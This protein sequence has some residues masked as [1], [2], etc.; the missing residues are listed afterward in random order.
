[1]VLSPT[2]LTSRDTALKYSTL[3]AFTCLLY[4]HVL[5]SGSEVELIWSHRWSF[6]KALF[7]FTRY[8]ALFAILFGVSVMFNDS[9][10]DKFCQ[11][12]LF[13]EI[14]STFI[15][16]LS[17]DI[18]LLLR[19]YAVYERNSKILAVVVTLCAAESLCILLIGFLRVPVEGTLRSIGSTDCFATDIPHIYFLLWVPALLFQTVLC[20]LMLY[21]A[22]RTYKD[23]W[24]SPL[25]SLI[26]RDSILYFL[27]IF[28]VYLLN[29]L[30]YALTPAIAGVA[31]MW[32]LAIPCVLGAQLLLNMRERYFKEN[33]VPVNL[34]ENMH[35]DIEIDAFTPVCAVK[36]ETDSKA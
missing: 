2:I 4:D 8:F 18:I 24:K 14:A 27:T 36:G 6:G 7:I 19:I 21:K 26:I 20:T 31:R 5:K 12:Y 25:L 15:A 32:V 16:S 22:W 33:T 1:M 23:D 28:T 35:A 10:T 30:L 9:L 3:S 17:A 29:C 13:W 11:E 34:T